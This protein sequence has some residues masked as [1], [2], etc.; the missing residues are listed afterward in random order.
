MPVH[1]MVVAQ[2]DPAVARV[3]V[4]RR[5]AAEGR[6]GDER[7]PGGGVLG[8]Q[9]AVRGGARVVAAVVAERRVDVGVDLVRAPGERL[10]AHVD[11]QRVARRVGHVGLDDPVAPRLRGV[12]L[13]VGEAVLVDQL[14]VLVRGVGLAIGERLAVGHDQLQVA[15]R[16]RAE[17][18]VVDLGQLAALQRVP[19]LALRRHRR[20]EALLVGRR[21]ERL[22]ARARRGPWSSARRPPPRARQRRWRGRRTPRTDR[23]GSTTWDAWSSSSRFGRPLATR[24]RG[25]PTHAMLWRDG[26]RRPDRHRPGPTG[27]RRLGLHRGDPAPPRRPGSRPLPPARDGHVARGVDRGHPAR[28]RRTARGPVR[29]RPARACTPSSSSTSAATASRRWTARSR[30]SSAC[31]KARSCRGSRGPGCSA[32]SGPGR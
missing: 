19:D 8:Q 29:A 5:G 3:Q 18:G 22:G 10:E 20:A 30:R 1:P 2:V 32:P 7:A 15:Q 13:A 9:R 6:L 11:Q 14:D 26:H 17:V 28:G 24:L 4:A 21:P 23:G 16:G 27:S 12:D 31:S 25:R